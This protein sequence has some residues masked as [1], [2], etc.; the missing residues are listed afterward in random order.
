MLQEQM[1]WMWSGSLIPFIQR[2]VD[3]DFV[4]P[5]RMPHIGEAEIILLGPEER[6]GVKSFALAQDVARSSLPL[7]FGNDKVLDSEQVVVNEHLRNAQNLR[8][9]HAQAIP[10]SVNTPNAEKCPMTAKTRSVLNCSLRWREKE[11]RRLFT[12][13]PTPGFMEGYLP[14]PPVAIAALRGNAYL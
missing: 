9:T 6:N 11:E 8:A 12:E 14:S 13:S 3:F 4:P 2:S 7:A 1:R 5:L 10:V